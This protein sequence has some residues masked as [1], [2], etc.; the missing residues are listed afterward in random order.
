MCQMNM[1]LI[2][3]I[4]SLHTKGFEMLG[5]NVISKDNYEITYNKN[6]TDCYSNYVSN[7]DVR[8]KQEFER[9]IQNI[10]R[11]F[12]KIN[13]TTTICLLP[14]MKELY[15]N[16][17]EYFNSDEYE[18]VSTEAWQVYKDFSKLDDINTKCELDVKLELAKDMSEFAHCLM[19]SYRTDD[20]E[21]PY[22]DLD[23]GYIKCY[24]NYKKICDEIESEFYYIK[25]N[26]E[27]VGTTQSTYNSKVC[28]IYSLGIC[29][30]YRGKGIG[31]EVVKK[32]LQ[33]CKSKDIKVAYLQTELGFLP[34]KLYKKIGFEDLCTAYYYLKK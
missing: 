34:N 15:N 6:I 9:V 3:D 18:L 28:G 33:M 16:Q 29:K 23:I 25:V 4:Y 1:D 22:G 13:R 31:K 7:F 19:A 20:E 26:N 2:K 27:I 5:Y 8:D 21:D 10:D 30:E 14:F 24:E 11:D 12:K 17:S 32:Q